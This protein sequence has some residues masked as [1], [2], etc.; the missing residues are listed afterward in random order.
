ML[1]WFR[2]PSGSGA[3]E[4]CL[5]LR[6]CSSSSLTRRE[7]SNAARA[8][9]STCRCKPLPCNQSGA[10]QFQTHRFAFFRQRTPTFLINRYFVFLCL[11]SSCTLLCGLFISNCHIIE[12]EFKMQSCL[13][14]LW[15]GRYYI[16]FL[17]RPSIIQTLG[18]ADD[19]DAILLAAFF[20][21]FFFFFLFFN[22]LL[23]IN[24]SSIK[25][26][27]LFNSFFFSPYSMY[28]YLI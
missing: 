28:Y 13:V 25:I 8:P 21:L 18:L 1:V 20:L 3:T 17:Y 9:R 19:A 15:G 11:S 6:K 2:L 24:T 27:R 22:L 7:N 5:M 26:E 4:G 12:L 23:L 14:H 16:F 10:R